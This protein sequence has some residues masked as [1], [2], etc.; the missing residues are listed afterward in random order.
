MHNGVTKER[1]G[2]EMKVPG[3]W[4]RT[5]DHKCTNGFTKERLGSEMKDPGSWV[6]TPDHKCTNGV[7]KERL[8]SEMKGPGSEL[9]ITNIIPVNTLNALGIYNR[10]AADWEVKL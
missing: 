5:P 2:S 3:S 4:V 9:R 1:L 6:R 10:K 7:T 8:G